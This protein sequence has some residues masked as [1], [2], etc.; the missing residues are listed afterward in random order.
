MPMILRRAQGVSQ[1]GVALRR[2]AVPCLAG[3]RRSVEL[4]AFEYIPRAAKSAGASV[5]ML[6]P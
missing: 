4:C 2:R 3:P 5:S 6:G 1:P